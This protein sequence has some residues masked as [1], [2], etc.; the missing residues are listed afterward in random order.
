MSP[1]QVR[2]QGDFDTPSFY[3]FCIGP[4]DGGGFPIPH[5]LFAFGPIFRDRTP[6]AVIR[7]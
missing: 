5:Y 3:Y 2:G 6:P 7:L 1:H 4:T